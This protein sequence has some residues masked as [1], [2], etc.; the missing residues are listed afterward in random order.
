M[1]RN[2]LHASAVVVSA[3]ILASCGGG[4][5]SADDAV[6]RMVAG[7][8]PAVVMSIE[9]KELLD[10][11][12]ITNKE[13]IPSFVQMMFSDKVDYLTKPES[14]GLDF[15]G[16]TYISIL[17][18][19]DGVG[20]WA[21]AKIKDKEALEKTLKEEGYSKFEEVEGFNTITEDK[22]MMMGW[23]DQLLITCVSKD[24]DAKKEFTKLVGY[25]KEEKKLSEGFEKFF[26][27]KA[28]M[29]FMSN[30]NKM[31]DLQKNLGESMGAG[32]KD[33]E[34]MQKMMSKFKGSYSIWSVDFENDKIVSDFV[35]GL[36]EAT[37]KEMNFFAK[38][39]TPDDMLAQIGDENALGYFA[40][41]GD[42]GG[43]IKWL[44]GIT[45]EDVLSE[46]K[47]ETGLD[48]D[49]I[50]SSLKGNVLFSFLGY[51]KREMSFG[52]DENGQEM[53]FSYSV[54]TYSFVASLKS[55]YIE[56]LADSL[57]KDKKHADN[58]FTIESDMF[59]AFRNG[60]VFS[61]N[62]EVLMSA[63]VQGVKPKF[64]K[65]ASSV[66]NKPVSFYFD[67]SRMIGDADESEKTQKIA[68][69]FKYVLGGMD[70]NGGHAEL[71]LNNGGKNSLW[72]LI[73][74]TVESTADLATGF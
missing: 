43:Y 6:K 7:N 27:S 22:E 69:K 57:L 39:G 61:T 18:T 25:I 53:K 50:V 66:I 9:I 52:M 60:Y 71:H 20:G 56:K 15:S 68:K 10:K 19:S 31:I 29:A 47:R 28:D 21:L 59:V 13:N 67:L 4:S 73:N 72:T 49:A 38:D 37:K 5:P 3:L 11:G 12:G 35:N 33:V 51:A 23:N 42:V 63:S 70:I 26:E 36:S 40:M 54:P 45:G 8:E 74:L 34:M 30:F 1:T 17:P 16:R 44:G 41:N 65:A 24:G 14:M 48:V 2:F 64:A 62:N 55:D 58:Y 46:A 32:M